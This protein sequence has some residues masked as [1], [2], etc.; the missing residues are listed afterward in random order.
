MSNGAKALKERAK[1]YE[2]PRATARMRVGNSSL[3][4]VPEPVKKPEP[5]NAVTQPKTRIQRGWR[6]A[7][8]KGTKDCGGQ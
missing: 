4:R 3:A 1:L 6:A 2:R 7:A 5:K 8:K